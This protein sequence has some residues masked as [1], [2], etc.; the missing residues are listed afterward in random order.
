ML[1]DTETPPWSMDGPRLPSS[2]ASRI[3]GGWRP[4]GILLSMRT[5]VLNMQL[6]MDKIMHSVFGVKLQ[7]CAE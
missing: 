7:G 3:V 6:A 2:R 1:R 5:E 4:F